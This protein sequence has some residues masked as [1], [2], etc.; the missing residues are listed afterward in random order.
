MKKKVSI[1]VC[2]YNEQLNIPVVVQAIHSSMDTTNYRYEIILVNDGSSDDS[3]V[4]IENLC[5]TDDKLYFIELSRNFGHQNALKAGLNFATGDCIISMDGDMQHP[6]RLLPQLIEKWEEGYDIVYTRRSED[7]TLSKKKRFTSKYYY[8][9]INFVSNIKLEEGV[10]D[11]RLMSRQSAKILANIKGSDLFIRGIVNWMGFKQYPI[12]YY[13]E[14]RFSGETKYTFKKM[15]TLAVNGILS[16]STKPLHIALYL[17][18]IISGLSILFIP[19]AI[20]SL[21]TGHVMA[22]WTSL[23]LTVS[24]LGGIQLFILGFIGL[25]IGRIFAITKDFPAYIVR[26]TNINEE[27]E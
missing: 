6:P 12:D 15:L 8:K 17:G 9:T 5:K 26:N 19:Y 7:K 11:F 23:I 3:Q 1:V 21:V 20:T 13:P 4:V 14:K 18:L 22:G 10:A 25:Y 24:L 2:C 16:F 27:N